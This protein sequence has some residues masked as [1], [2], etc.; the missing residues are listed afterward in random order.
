MKDRRVLVVLAKWPQP[1]RAKTRLSQAIG[2][3]NA[4]ALAR[5]FLADTLA[6]GARSGADE[7]LV[8]YAPRGA[9][10]EF[11]RLAPHVRL[12][13]QPNA[14]FGSRLRAALRA[15]H[16]RAARVVL[17]GTDSPTLPATTLRAA[18]ERLDAVDAVL[19]PATDGGYYL[20]GARRPLPSSVFA[21]MPWST[22]TV[23]AETLRRLASAQLRV[24]V[25]PRWY[26][27]DDATGVARLS[28]D[29][30]LGRAPRTR[31]ALARIE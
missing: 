6:L 31:D 12:V 5:A 8:A 27:V 29:F 23:A 21:Q 7:L 24:A 30:R 13:A 9:R 11:R 22:S 17:I 10:T 2:T 4:M 20:I 15:G 26:D 16:A 3:V 28:R 19:G 1:G 18:F 25:L 14:V